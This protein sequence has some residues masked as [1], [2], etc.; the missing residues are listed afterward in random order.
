MKDLCW[1]LFVCFFVGSCNQKT[2]STSNQALF[3]L[4]DTEQTGIHFTNEIQEDTRLNILSFE[5][6]YNGAGVGVAD[7]NQDSLPDLFF[8]SNMGASKLYL[9]KGNFKFEDITE[10]SGIDTRGKWASGVSIVDINQDGFPDIYLCFAGPHEASERANALYINNGKNQFTDQAAA[11]GL[12]DTGHTVQAVFFDYDRDDDLDCY[13]LTNITDELGPNIIRPK[14]NNGEMVN[15]DRLYRND[16][17]GHFTNV[18]REAGILKEGYGLGIAV[19]D[20]NQDGWPDLFISNDYL[21][22][23]LLYINNK[24]G[25]FT[26]HAAKAFKHTSYSAMGN[27]VGDI[28]NDGW[29]DLVEVDMLPPD[30]F[31]QKLMLGFTNHDRYRSELQMGYDPQFMRNSLHLHQGLNI[32]TVPVFS[33][34]GQLAG[35]AATD[36]SWS[37]L[38]ADFDLDGMRDLFIT[39]GYPRDITNRDFITYQ[40]QEL[41]RSNPKAPLTDAQFTV[42]KKL[43]GAFLHNFMFRNEGAYRFTDQS[44][45]WGFSKDAYSS[46]AA[47]ADFDNDGDLDL[48]V[49]NTGSPAS[50]YRN[51]ATAQQDHHYISI[52]L[53]GKAGNR[54]GIGA[55]CRL[56]SGNRQWFAEQQVVRG[57]QSSIDN[58]LVFGLGNVNLIDSLL[59]TWPDGQTEWVKNPPVNKELVLSYKNSEPPA[60]KETDYVPKRFF[61]NTSDRLGINFEHRETPYTDFNIQPLLPHKFSTGGPVLVSADLNG[62][63][64]DDFF[65]GGAYN[66]SG[67][68][69]LQLPDGNFHSQE[70]DPGKKFPEDRGAVFFDADGDGDAD[71]YV[72]SGGNE[73]A[74]GSPYYFDRLYIN[75]GMGNFSLSKDLLPAISTSGSVVIAADFDKDGDQDLFVGGELRPQH[76]P[77]GGISQLLENR[78]GKFVQVAAEIAPGL[79]TIGMVKGAVWSDLNRDGWMDLVIV[80]EWM[81]V[82]IYMNKQG[83][84]ENQTS[85]QG[86][87]QT[88]G[89]WSSV[90]AG[91]FNG[92]GQ[93]DLVLGNHGLNSRYG[94]APNQPLGIYWHE[95]AKTGTRHG[96]ISY[97]MN[98][99]TYPI[100]P[101]D[102]LI[103][104]LPFL[105]KKFPFYSDYAKARM[106][107]LFPAAELKAAVY[108]EMNQ[109][110]S[111]ILLNG[112]DSGWKFQ[113]LPVEAQFAPIKSILV[114]D[115]DGDGKQDLLLAGNEL[116]FEV[117]NGPI[118]ALNGLSLKGL[119]D[120]RFELQRDGFR[121]TGEGNSLILVNRPGKTKLV[122]AGQNNG[123]LLKFEVGTV[124]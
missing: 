117:I 82:T 118:D 122:I 74:E 18:S 114:Q 65:V 10:T 60:F 113:A 40:A 85:Q 55:T 77:E 29:P 116:G 37:P 23:N 124:K 102:D 66:Q 3:E 25:T 38:L 43:E 76:Y 24:N 99:E 48:V 39:N 81:P 54:D 52:R 30:N 86:L 98:G 105:R 106:A 20:V 15:T 33:E 64:R 119:G 17:N 34:I 7:F 90:Q 80:G 49:V 1:L 36:W 19:T 22:N 75:N 96:V 26:D 107:D 57:Y 53:E 109:M 73:F 27:D 58:R 31:R 104:Q 41:A 16:G 93:P 50:V 111:G 71:L 67:L 11:Y 84:L 121:V 13:L 59:I 47:Y 14:R 91:D 42:L 8:A 79:E 5:Y 45:Q 97:T 44:E 112:V 46:G 83:K 120:G 9:N 61:E 100:H 51:H 94:T 101:R 88:I 56:F 32:E 12:A 69:Y 6:F 70:L 103:M 87:S 89:W 78:N 108:V 4:L 110:Q 28:N 95:F 2:S 115:W 72:V 123:S 21:S 35:I 62:D 92:D 63:K 68:I